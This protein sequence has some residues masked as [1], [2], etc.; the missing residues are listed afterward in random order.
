MKKILIVDDSLFMRTV[1]K[2]L[3]VG[4]PNVLNQFEGFEI[5]EA[6]GKLDALKKLE[7]STPDIILLDIVMG[8][9]GI[10][11][12]ELVELLKGKYDPANIIIVSS[13]G[14]DHLKQKCK[15]LGINHYLQKPITNSQVFDAIKRVMA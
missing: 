12:V 2:D 1:L 7:I 10:E 4:K 6:S 9:S 13:V 14:Q 15:Q 5:M 3:L 8:E 11:G